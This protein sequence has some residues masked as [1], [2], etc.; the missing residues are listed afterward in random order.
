MSMAPVSGEAD[1]AE[2]PVWYSTKLGQWTL[3]LAV[4]VAMLFFWWLDGKTA[5]PFDACA[6]D[7]L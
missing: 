1:V 5:W 7:A 3:T 2:R 6:S 4:F